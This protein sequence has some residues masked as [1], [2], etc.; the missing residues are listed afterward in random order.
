MTSKRPGRGLLI[1]LA[2]AI[3]APAFAAGDA[4]RGK[5]FYQ[6]CAACHGEDARGN[7]DNAAPQLAG[8]Y[9]WYLIRQL[10]N[11]RDGI[12][13]ADPRDINGA[14]M[15]PMAMTLPDDQAIEDV[16]AYIVRKRPARQN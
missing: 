6:I 7:E 9:S 3:C 12:R 13:G 1:L 14:M 10:K 2:S 16:V 8:Q 11:F 15:R 5:Q 4:D